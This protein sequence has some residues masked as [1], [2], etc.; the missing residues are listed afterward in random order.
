MALD[1][2]IPIKMSTRSQVII[3]LLSFIILGLGY[4][5]STINL[6][7]KEWLSRS[8][9]LVV[10]LGIISGFSGIIQE[11]LLISRLEIRKRVELLQKKRKLRLIKAEKDFIEKELTD[12]EGDF[13]DQANNLMNSIKFNVGI[14]EG[15][16]LIFGTVIW[17]F[18]DII[19][20][21]LKQL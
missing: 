12:I 8:G 7:N 6:L 10:V 9:S 21:A 19:M 5:F 15:L 14:I 4:Y 2:K 17:G 3:V 13:T 1:I 11:R 20:M 16:L 18:G